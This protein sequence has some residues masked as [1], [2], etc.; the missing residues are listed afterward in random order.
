MTHQKAPGRPAC[1]TQPRRARTRTHA[2][3]PGVASSDPTGGVS[4]FTHNS[5]A[6]PAGAPVETQKTR[7]TGLVSDRVY[8]RQTT[9]ARA[10]EDGRRRDPPGTTPSRGPERVRRGASA[11]LLPRQG[12][13]AGRSLVLG[14]SP[15]V[16]RS[17]A[18]DPGAK[19]PV[20]GRHHGV[21]KADRSTESGQTG[22]GVAHHTGQRGTPERQAAG[23]NQGT[24]TGAEQQQPPAGANPESAHN[25]Q[26]TTAQEKVPGN[27]QPTHHKPRPGLAGCR[28]SAHTDAQTYSNT[29]ASNGRAQPKPQ[30]KHTPT[31]H[32]PA[33]NG[34]L[35][36]E[37]TCK[38]THPNTPNQEWGAQQKSEPKHRHQK[39]HTV[40]KSVFPCL[41]VSFTCF[42]DA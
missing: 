12:P 2:C 36:A 15:R 9:A 30:T 17:C 8:T 11:A 42:R 22:R 31:P 35:Q 21:G 16:L 25:T 13:A 6:A 23:H 26:R 7:E 29:S 14:R 41:K 3:D 27:T 19:A 5:T 1:L 24:G 38:H 20:R 10:A 39:P 33:R 40:R 18:V 32:T 4:K 34:G 28:R 37:G